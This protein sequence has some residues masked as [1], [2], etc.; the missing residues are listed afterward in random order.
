MFDVEDMDA[1]D[2]TAARRRGVDTDIEGAFA[3]RVLCLLDGVAGLLITTIRQCYN[4]SN[5]A[6][7]SSNQL[8]KHVQENKTRR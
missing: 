8:E 6:K 3:V 1:A 4:S 2:G 5:D 7:A